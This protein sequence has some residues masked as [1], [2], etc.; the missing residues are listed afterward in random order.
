MNPQTWLVVCQ[1]ASF[2]GALTVLVSGVGVWFFGS[3]LEAQKDAKIS[4]LVQGKNDLLELSQAYVADLR[5][6]DAALARLNAQLA[7]MQPVL[8]IIEVVKKDDRSRAIQIILGTTFPVEVP[9]AEIL[10]EFS[11]E[12]LSASRSVRGTGSVVCNFEEPKF[13]GNLVTLSGGPLG[14]TCY[15]FVEVETNGPAEILRHNLRVN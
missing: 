10:I 1:V 3:Q 7:N 4:E 11:N 13:Q 15:L 6:K 9:R 14:A 12:V 5:T 8:S 2:L